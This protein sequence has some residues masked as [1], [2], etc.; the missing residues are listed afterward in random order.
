MSPKPSNPAPKNGD[1][2]IV[3]LLQ[4]RKTAGL[5]QLLATH[6][7]CIRSGLARSFGTTVNSL[8]IDDA[9]SKATFNAWRKVDSFDAGKGTLRA[10]FFVIARNATVELLRERKRRRWETRG[11]AVEELTAREPNTSKMPSAFLDVLRRCIGKLPRLQREIIE[12]DL[13]TGEVA[14][15]TELARQLRT[16]KNSIYVSRSMARKALRQLLVQQGYVPGEGKSQLL[17]N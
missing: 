13:R 2:E 6:G 8:E 5:R 17:W 11:D 15:A 7:D 14:D 16:T 4:A 3:R 1:A 12:A 9:M 10:W